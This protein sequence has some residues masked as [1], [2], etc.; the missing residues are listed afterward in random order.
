MFNILA[1]IPTLLVVGG[2]LLLAQAASIPTTIPQWIAPG[3]N[4][5]RGPCPM[6]N[7]LA[8]HGLIPRSG[9]NITNKQ[10]LEGL[11]KVSC[12]VDLAGVFLTGAAVLGVPHRPDGS[13]GLDDLRTHSTIEHDASLTRNDFNLSPEHDNWTFNQ[14]LYDQ[15]R[16]FVNAD[17]FM[18]IHSMAL[19]RL[20]RQ[21]DTARRNPGNDIGL[22]E[23]LI[24]HGEAAVLLAFF[25][26][27]ESKINN[28]V[29]LAFADSLFQNERF[30]YHLGWAPP[31]IPVT[32]AQTTFVNSLIIAEE[33]KI[34]GPFPSGGL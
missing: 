6:L 24:A 33:V 7:S 29:P 23:G 21:A 28:K 14:T 31:P 25:G 13:F 11:K 2:A 19:A 32:V 12:G 18:D 3:P 9:R 1:T 26:W 17:G 10:Y 8:N 30:P 27:Q 15:M 16:S 34:A 5:V 20:N 22:R 4:D